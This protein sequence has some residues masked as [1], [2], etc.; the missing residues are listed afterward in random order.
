M[1]T[2]VVR[3]SLIAAIALCAACMAGDPEPDPDPIPDPDDPDALAGCSP[4]FSQDLLPEYRVTIAPDHWEALE[5]EFLHRD[6]RE[7]QGLNP[8]PYHPVEFEYDGTSVPGVLIRL[9]GQSSWRETVAFDERPKMQFV[10]AFNEVDRRGR[11]MGVRKIELDMPRTDGSFLR[12][13]LALYYLRVA[14][15][16]AQCANSARLVINGELYGLYT[17]LER[18]DKEFLQRVF[19]EDRHGD[20]WKGGRFIKTN[21]DTFSW[22]RLDAFWMATTIAELEAVVDVQSSVREWA[23]EAMPPH[24]DGYYVGRANYYLYDHPSR[25]FVWLPHDLDAAFDFISPEADPQFP[26]CSG[27]NPNDREHYALVMGDQFWR[28]RYVDELAAMRDAYHV[29]NLELRVDAWAAQIAES[30]A[31]DP[32]KP[33]TTADHEASVA[34]LR[35]YMAQRAAAVDDWL[36]CRDSGGPDEDGDG[37]MWCFDCD[38]ADPGAY[39]GAPEICGN[40]IDDDCDGLADG[41][42][43]GVECQ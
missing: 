38:D 32:M 36:A 39:P 9:K 31:D 12:Q 35:G 28:E 3:K 8:K 11:F 29:D 40:G 41:F 24:A 25:G 19:G 30:A 7:A 20:L 42:P 13:R 18:L 15:I 16:D 22:A 5:Y 26:N 21:E 27:R 43:G 33:F 1:T 4:I 23:A 10:I 2:D 14:G 37:V 6:E 34:A 17:N